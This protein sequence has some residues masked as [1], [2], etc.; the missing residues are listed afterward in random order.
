MCMGCRPRGAWPDRICPDFS[1]GTTSSARSAALS[2]AHHCHCNMQ[3][4]PAQ[5]RAFGLAADCA[6][7]RAG[8]VVAWA[9]AD[10]VC[11][12]RRAGVCAHAAGGS[13]RR[14][15]PRM[16]AAGDRGDRRRTAADPGTARADAAG[17]ADFG[18]GSTADARATAAAVR[19][20]R[21]HAAPWLAQFGI[22]VSLDLA[23]LK[24]RGLRY[25]NANYED[26]LGSLLSSL[27]LG[28]SVALTVVGNAVLIPVALVLPAAGLEA[29]RGTRSGTGAPAH[30]AGGRLFCRGG[31]P[32]AGTV[33]A[34]P[35]AGHADH[36]DLLQYRAGPVRAGPGLAHWPVHRHGD[37]RS[38]RR[39]RHRAGAGR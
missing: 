23:S 4:T 18:Q 38:L 8:A 13:A 16:G 26:A 24:V 34:W 22:K 32:G 30:A 9:R 7:C 3:F 20:A 2:K 14:G 29:F 17:R 21:R 33:S 6:A 1:F 37:V 28:G 15:R 27:K 5:K 19:Q 10:A 11:R 35:I 31:R 36:G 25:L 12:R 39:I